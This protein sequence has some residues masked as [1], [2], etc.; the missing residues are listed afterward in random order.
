MPFGV[1]NAPAVFMDLLN[2][3]FTPYLDQFVMVFIHD[4]LIYSKTKEEYTEH[5]RI[6]LQILRQE[7]LYAK[8]SKCSFWLDHVSFLG[9]IISWDGISVDP[10]IVEAVKDWPTPK[11]ITEARSFLGL[12]GY[13]RRFV[14]NFSRIVESNQAD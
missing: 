13:Y 5:L 2:H 9:H 10:S 3:Y 11:S 6:V 14:Q 8:L 7:K 12:A 1:T 4:I